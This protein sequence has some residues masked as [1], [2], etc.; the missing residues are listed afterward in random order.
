M[1]IPSLHGEMLH[2]SHC[3]P[4]HVAKDTFL[5]RYFQLVYFKYHP[6][7]FEFSAVFGLP[8]G[9]RFLGTSARLK[10]LTQQFLN[11]AV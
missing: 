2:L 1:G 7:S 11:S 9:N 3:R 5:Q 10:N 8:V 4:Q 6:H